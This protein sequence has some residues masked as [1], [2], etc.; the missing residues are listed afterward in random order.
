MLD[1]HVVPSLRKTH[2]TQV[3]PTPMVQKQGPSASRFLSKQCP[4]TNSAW[5]VVICHWDG[6]AGWY[7]SKRVS[8]DRYMKSLFATGAIFFNPGTTTLFMAIIFRSLEL[9]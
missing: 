7:Q 9:T 5:Q 6:E 1:A 8:V 2:Y 3:S 4:R